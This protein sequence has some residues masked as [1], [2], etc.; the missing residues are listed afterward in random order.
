MPLKP[1]ETFRDYQKRVIDTKS[2][3]W[4]AAKYYNAT[5]W[6]GSGMTTSCHHPRLMLLT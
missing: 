1:G 6:L 4:C 5:I 3:S 2:K